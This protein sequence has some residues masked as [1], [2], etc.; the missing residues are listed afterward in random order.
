MKGMWWVDMKKL[1][2]VGVAVWAMAL[3][4]GEIVNLWPEGKMPLKVANQKYDPTLEWFAP[5]KEANRAF[6]LIIPGGG[7]FKVG[8][9][10]SV[11]AHYR[12]LGYYVGRLRYR[13]PRPDGMEIYR[14]A[15][16]DG[17]RAVRMV[18]AEAEKRGY[19]PEKIG[20]LGSS[21]GGHLTLLLALNSQTPAYE[22]VD[23]VDSTPA[24]V[25]W[26]IPVYPAYVLDDGLTSTNANRGFDAKISG[27]FKF[28]AKTCPMCF[29]HGGAD[30]YS[31]NGS[32]MLYRRLR[33]MKVPAEL[34]LLADR[35]HSF[36]LNA[37]AGTASA[38]WLDRADE[39]V[40]QMN[41]LGTLGEARDRR[42]FTG[43]WTKD[44][45]VEKLWPDGCPD[46]QTCQTNAPFLTWYL[47]KDLKTKAIQIVFP[48][49]A[50]SHC[51][52]KGE[53][54]PEAD[55]FNR[56]GMTTVVVTYRTPRPQG[57]P[58]HM[59]AWQDAQRAIRMVRY[60]AAGRG[61]DPDRNGVMG[62]SAGGHLTLMCATT[63]R[64]NAYPPMDEIDAVSAKVQWACPTYPAY[65]LSDGADGA[66][67]KGGNPDDAVIVSDFAFDADTPPMCFL[68]GDADVI[69]SMG[70]VKV[71]EKLRRAGVQ[72]E[73][74]TYATRPHCFQFTC[75]DG[76]GSATW[77][78][79]IWEFMVQK[80]INR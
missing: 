65:V 10:E 14:T 4:A 69:S 62:F 60:E 29:F 31:P 16:A 8:T 80:G 43:K 48:G 74:H 41:F 26:A 6:M 52:A 49:G 56:K 70:S 68:H 39:F 72:C 18:R 34:H 57:F 21:A 1:I 32:T 54:L 61:L 24:H 3:G 33:E 75:A 36:M 55:Y 42:I 46:A 58:K 5:T 40:R 76:T 51:N 59:S 9:L 20:V 67:A 2:V 53:G 30:K 37:K 17:Q 47:P 7:Y 27:A 19:D 77:H 12:K 71:W 35:P 79:R 28:D 63:S 13:T 50:Y 64:T 66:N 23:A 73:L 11:V 15:W 45:V 78:D 22:P 25:N 38:T 44:Q